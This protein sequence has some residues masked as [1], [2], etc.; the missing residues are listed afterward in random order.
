VALPPEPIFGVTGASGG[1]GSRVARRLADAGARQ[2]LVVRNP[3]RAPRISGTEVRTAEYDDASLLP[4]AFAGLTT[5]FLVSA[6]EHPDRVRLHRQAIDAAVEAGVTRIV[7]TSFLGAAPDAT[8]TFARDHHAT[9]EYLR[10]TGIATTFLRDSMYQDFLPSFASADDGVMRGPAGDG[11]VSAVARDDIADVAAR[12]L[13]E[14][15]VHDGRTYD[16]T[17]PSAFTLAEA[18]ELLSEISGRPVRYEPETEEQ[19]YASRA[20][21]GEAFEI[22]GWVTSYQAIATGELSAVSDAVET[23][24]GSPA[25]SFRDLLRRNPASWAHLTRGR[26]PG[27]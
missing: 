18:A 4:S 17:G 24:T 11:A 2:V 5:L 22:A 13:L 12:V 25:M 8:F 6:A 1:I 14:P 23:I 27:R 20:G 15:Y 9:E 16:V 10:A 21:A 26:G 19:A 7:Y 3:A